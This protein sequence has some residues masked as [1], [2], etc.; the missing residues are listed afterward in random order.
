MLPKS[1]QY[2]FQ[3]RKHRGLAEIEL[4]SGEARTTAAERQR[5]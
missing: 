5:E 2:L 1:S 4:P 3:T